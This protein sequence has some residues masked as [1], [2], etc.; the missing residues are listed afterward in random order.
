MDS[1][2]AANATPAILRLSAT[3]E[4]QNTIARGRAAVHLP[5]GNPDR[6]SA[7]PQGPG[8]TARLQAP[9]PA[10]G[11]E[12]PVRVLDPVELRTFRKSGT[13]DYSP[14]HIVRTVLS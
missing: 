10:P 9:V 13:E 11:P 12:R 1:H 14:G 7:R 4:A 5:A 2:P 3:E 8:M 6:E